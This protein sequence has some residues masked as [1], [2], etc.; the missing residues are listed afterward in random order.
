MIMQKIWNFIKNKKWWFIAGIVILVIIILASGKPEEGYVF[1]TAKVGDVSETILAT[2]QVISDTDLT[3]SFS[4]SGIVNSIPVSVGDRVSRGQILASL[5]NQSAIAGLTQAEAGLARAEAAY[6]QLL[7]GAAGE[8]IEVARVTLRNAEAD[9]NQTKIQQDRLV[10]NAYRRLLSD[11]LEAVPTG[12]TSDTAPAISG[13][14]T[15]TEEGQYLVRMYSSGGGTRFI[16]SGLESDDGLVNTSKPVSFGE[17]GLFIQFSE[18]DTVNTRWTIDVPNTR[19]ASYVTNLN[20]YEA[21]QETRDVSLATKSAAIDSAQANLDNLLAKAT[22]PEMALA[23]AD[24]LAAEGQYEAALAVL[25][26]TRI[27]AP[28]SGTITRVDAN[29]GELIQAYQSAIVLQDTEKLLLEANINEANITKVSVGTPV[30]ITFDAFSFDEVF[31][32]EVVNI[33]IASTLVSGVVNY[34]IKARLAKELAELR[35]G[36]TA[37]MTLVIDKKEGVLKIPGRAVYERDGATYVRIKNEDET[38]E[39]EVSVGFE[40]DGTEAEITSGLS[41]GQEVVI[42]PQ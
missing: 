35:P 1:E 41:E 22:G 30:E 16:V 4:K 38:Q 40:G 42:N 24:I 18:S 37:N 5:Q 26:D 13:T 36:M 29:P 10:Q 21:A 23:Q 15:G 3:L 20:A 27:R 33:D 7:A 39:V 2:G 9:Y 25:E 19:G 17:K 32:G 8:E 28:E 31:M 12:S 14:Y 34:R 6:Q 11:D